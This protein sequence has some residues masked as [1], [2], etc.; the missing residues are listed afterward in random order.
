MPLLGYYLLVP[1]A[2]IISVLLFAGTPLISPQNIAKAKKDNEDYERKTLASFNEKKEAD[3][4]GKRNTTNRNQKSKSN[5]STSTPNKSK[6]KAE[7]ESKEKINGSP[8]AGTK[9]E[10]GV[11]SA[12]ADGEEV[13]ETS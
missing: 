1:R 5:T 4:S 10:N 3:L 11:E 13:V 2:S 12:E 8:A 6:G 9:T 7:K